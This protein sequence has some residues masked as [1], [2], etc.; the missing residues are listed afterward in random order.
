M[1]QDTRMCAL[2]IIYQKIPE[3]V[4]G[5]LFKGTYQNVCL[6]IFY[7]KIPECVLGKSF[8]ENI[9]KIDIL[10]HDAIIQSAI[11]QTI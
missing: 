5:K 8:M 9:K 11:Y 6:E 2:K 4:L 10:F 3:H 1:K 7:G